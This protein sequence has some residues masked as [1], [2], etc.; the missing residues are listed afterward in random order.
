MPAD[1]RSSMSLIPPLDLVEQTASTH[2]PTSQ[3]GIARRSLHGEPINPP[4]DTALRRNELEV[5]CSCFRFY[6][7]RFRKLGMTEKTPWRRFQQSHVPIVE[8]R[9]KYVFGTVRAPVRNR[10]QYMHARI[11]DGWMDALAT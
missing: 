11:H 8:R 10:T 2:S 4:D 9:V 5:K 1:R 3:K 7:Y 6:C